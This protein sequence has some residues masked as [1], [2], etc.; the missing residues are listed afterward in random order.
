MFGGGA[1]TLGLL[2]A[3]PGAGAL[4]G[5]LTTGWVPRI[6]RQG[7]AVIAAVIVW[8]AAI[9]GF[10]LVRWLPAALALLAVAGCADVISAVFRSTIIQLGVPDD[11][12]RPADGRA[13]GRRHR[14]R[15]GSG[16]RRPGAV[17]AAFTP[18]TRWSPAAW[19][20]SPAR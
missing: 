10:G 5:A 7:R 17:A 15:R 6:R 4:V 16:T 19:P 3:A 20:A 9:T 14:R 18:V 1:R 8:G 2:Y 13:D 12:A 11:A